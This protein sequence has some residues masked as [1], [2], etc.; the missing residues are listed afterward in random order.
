MR[1][2]ELELDC[3]SAAIFTRHSNAGYISLHSLYEFGKIVALESTVSSCKI[4]ELCLKPIDETGSLDNSTALL[5]L[6]PLCYV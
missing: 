1:P 6:T 5:N 3:W 2:F 4:D